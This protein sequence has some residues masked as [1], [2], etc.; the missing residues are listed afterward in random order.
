[1]AT[2]V[3]TPPAPVDINTP[4]AQIA[5]VN[6]ESQATPTPGQPRNPDGTFAAPPAPPAAPPTPAAPTPENPVVMNDLGNGVFEVKYVTGETFKGTAA[7][8]L[9]KMGQAH[10]N[11]KLWAKQQVQQQTP[12]PPAA[13][14]SPFTDPAEAATANYVLDLIAKK[15]GLPN[16][17]ALASQFGYIDQNATD[18]ASQTVALQFQASQPDFNPT[19]ENSDKLLQVIND[20]GIGPAFDAAPRDQQVMMLKQAH[21]Y[22]LMNNVYAAKPKTPAAPSVPAPPP[23]APGGRTA[24][25]E[26]QLPD[27]L[28]ATLSDTPEQ[29]KAKWAEAQRL[30]Y[31]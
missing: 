23:P 17:E 31:V 2:P 5:Q 26:G 7:E 16:G 24:M 9:P 25:P 28:K 6:T 10:V 14:Q 8:L 4:A 18:Y 21:A 11:T 27:N 30:G 20:S 15:M 22:C 29:I 3:V 12:P 19:Q 1:M 13:P